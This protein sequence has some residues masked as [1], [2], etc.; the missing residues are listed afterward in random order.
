VNRVISG[1]TLLVFLAAAAPARD[2]DPW[3]SPDLDAEALTAARD[4]A[5]E[6]GDKPEAKRRMELLDRLLESLALEK[7][8]PDVAKAPDRLAEAQEAL[9]RAREAPA[10]EVPERVETEE[11][12]EEIQKPWKEARGRLQAA[13]ESLKKI[14]G[15]LTAFEDEVKDLPRGRR[16]PSGG[17][18]RRGRG[19]TPTSSAT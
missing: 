19:R 10:E 11:Q 15:D 8:L 7:R 3:E 18:T 13:T 1:L 14:E 2:A 9:K 12:L 17:W 16:K 6:L 5:K 4:A